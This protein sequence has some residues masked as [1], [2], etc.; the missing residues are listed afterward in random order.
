MFVA[1]ISIDTSIGGGN[2]L[3]HHIEVLVM[4]ENGANDQPLPGVQVT[5]TFAGKTFTGLTDENGVF[6]SNAIKGVKSGEYLAEV[7]DLVLTVFVWDPLLDI[8]D[9]T[10]GDGLPDELLTI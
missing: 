4:Q 3:N 9:D 7:T 8:V 1:A 10:D 6:R 5:V 2:K